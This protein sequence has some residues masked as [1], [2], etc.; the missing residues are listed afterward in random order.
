MEYIRKTYGVT[1]KRGGKVKFVTRS[2][3]VWLGHIRSAENGRLRVKFEGMD[4]VSTIDP[5]WN[6]EYL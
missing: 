3:T 6:L 4:Y 5:V 2:G 1:A